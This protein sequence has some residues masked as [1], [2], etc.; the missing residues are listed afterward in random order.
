MSISQ[1]VFENWVSNVITL[2]WRAQCMSDS[3]CL[4]HS[5]WLRYANSRCQSFRKGP[6]APP[7]VYSAAVSPGERNA[8]SPCTSWSWSLCLVKP[9][10]LFSS[11]GAIINNAKLHCFRSETRASIVQKEVLVKC[12][13]ST[14]FVFYDNKEQYDGTN[15]KVL[16][17]LRLCQVSP[18][19]LMPSRW[20]HFS[21]EVAPSRM[22]AAESHFVFVPLMQMSCSGLYL[23]SAR[24]GIFVFTWQSR[25]W[26]DLRGWKRSQNISCGFSNAGEAQSHSWRRCT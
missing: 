7:A 13:W 14:L 24:T 18:A 12:S 26:L 10:V 17:F 5:V 22:S 6:T 8:P 19:T 9:E 1:L 15:S 11:Q 4:C 2:W 20:G 3:V 21:A 16:G 25:S 23:Q